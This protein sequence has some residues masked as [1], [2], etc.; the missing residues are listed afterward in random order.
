VDLLIVFDREEEDGDTC[1]R[2]VDLLIVFDR[3][4]EDGDILLDKWNFSHMLVRYFLLLFLHFRPMTTNDSFFFDRKM[5]RSLR[6][7]IPT[8]NFKSMYFPSLSRV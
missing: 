3:E 2:Q 8:V 1:G 4:E 6:N 7:V 5:L